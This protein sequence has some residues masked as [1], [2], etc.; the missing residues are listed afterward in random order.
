MDLQN[1]LEDEVKLTDNKANKKFKLIDKFFN[2]KKEVF[3]DRRYNSTLKYLY[4]FIVFLL[5]IFLYRAFDLQVFKY[6]NYQNLA[7][8]NYLR[9]SFIFP[10]RG[11]I[12]DRNDEFLVKNVPLFIVH[13]N[14]DKCLLKTKIPHLRG[15]FL[16]LNLIDSTNQG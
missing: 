14:I 8:K 12:F 10:D 6:S 1:L 11:L 16:K 2:L 9:S 5:L 13:I 15:I 4:Y 3:L 7:E